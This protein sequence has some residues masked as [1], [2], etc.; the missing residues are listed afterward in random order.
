MEK[1][2]I[3][4]IILAA[5][6]GTR[7]KSPL[8]KVLHPVAGT[9]MIARVIST[10]KQVESAEVRVVVGHGKNLIENIV[11]NMGAITFEQKE[12]KGTAH[13]VM[14]ADYE[15]LEGDVLILNGDHPLI[16]REDL[17]KAIE[18]FR[19]LKADVAVLTAVL[20]NPQEFGRIV[21]HNNEVRAIV[22]AKDASSETLKICEINTGAYFVKAS[23]LKEYL[24]Q[25][26][27]AN[28]QKE[29][30]LTDLIALCVENSKKV[31]GVQ[32]SQRFALGVN[33]QIQLAKATSL[34][35]QDKITALMKNGVI[36]INP[37]SCYIED[38]VEIAAGSVVYPNV[39]IKGP[40]KIGAFAV[41]EPNTFIL[42]SQI[43]ESVQIKMGSHLEK[44]KISSKA[45]VGPY[46]RLRPETIIG[47][48]AKVGNFVEMK[49]VKFGKNSKASH[50]TYLGDA[51]I[52]EDVNIGCGTITCNYAVDHKK[53]ETIIGDRVFVGSDSQF[54]APVKVG[55]DAIVGSGSTVTKDVPSKALAVARSK[56]V[57]I[58][59]YKPKKDS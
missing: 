59:N 7:M 51:T 23:I 47:E 31:I 9:P 52:G 19:E 38:D 50:L 56:Q 42:S 41:L 11:T 13:A 26:M 2:R 45:Q 24:P 57:N 37:K 3:T 58:E 39:F 6:Q 15:N 44:V 21:R 49:K 20:K 54:V 4:T 43:G 40:T 34:A 46:A 27:P 10:A 53:Y 12:Q 36:F 48:N 29:F 55:D 32:V 18:E 25:I 35:V 5:G 17:Q 8:P 14:S 1:N 28:V 33:D 16:A 30:Y 22:E